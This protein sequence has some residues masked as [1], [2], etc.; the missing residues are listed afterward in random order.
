MK[1]AFGESTFG[2]IAEL[3]W[4]Q[5]G[6]LD[7]NTLMVLALQ[8]SRTAYEAITVIDELVQ[9]YGYYS[10]GEVFT[11]G[12][13]NEIWYMEMIGKGKFELVFLFFYLFLII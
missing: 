12:D 6:L 3:G 2:G 10:G 13:P 1:V 5:Q 8:R 11:I 9:K 4:S 7:Y